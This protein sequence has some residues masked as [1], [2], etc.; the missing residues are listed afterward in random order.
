[1]LNALFLGMEKDQCM[2]SYICFFDRGLDVLEQRVGNE[3][4][5]G[6]VHLSRVRS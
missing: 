5:L 2:I 3:A 4:L 1:M 6:N